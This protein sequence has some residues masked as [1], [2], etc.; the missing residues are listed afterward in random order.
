[1]AMWEEGATKGHGETFKSNRCSHYIYCG[2]PGDT[3]RYMST[4]IKLCTLNKYIYCVIIIP[5]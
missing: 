1:M 3:C 4:L 5:Q 2:T